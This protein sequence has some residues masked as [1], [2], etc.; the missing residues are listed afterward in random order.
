MAGPR[1]L[2]RVRAAIHAR[3]NSYRTERAYVH[4]IRRFNRFHRRRH[5]AEMGTRE[6]G[7]F[8]TDLA[9]RR[10]V[11]AS[12]RDQAL[13]AILFL[14]RTVREQ[15]LDGIENAARARRRVREPIVL[16]NDEVRAIFAHL[17]EQHHLMALLMWCWPGYVPEADD[18]QAASGACAAAGPCGWRRG[19]CR[20][21]A[22]SDRPG[23]GTDSPLYPRVRHRDDSAASRE[24][25]YSDRANPAIRQRVTKGKDPRRVSTPRGRLRTL[26]VSAEARLQG[27]HEV[28]FPRKRNFRFYF[29]FRFRGI[30]SGEAVPAGGVDNASLARDIIV[31][32]LPTVAVN[33]QVVGEIAAA[34]RAG[35]VVIDTCTIGVEA[36]ERTAEALAATGIGYLDAPVSGLRARAQDGTLTTMCAG[37]AATV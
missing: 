34:A 16:P 10:N 32:S 21:H 18:S 14:Y 33:R 7:A 24:R 5:P 8:L 35:S 26:P 12:T 11:S 1:L 2:E 22:A 37:D 13:D 29:K 30:V 28:L 4:W 27:L 3:H 9:V 6:V 36:A 23:A 15:T 20:G 19:S 17:R 25:N 31:L